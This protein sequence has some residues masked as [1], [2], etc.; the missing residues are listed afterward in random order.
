M[1]EIS[2]KTLRTAHWIMK[3]SSTHHTGGWGENVSKKPLQDQDGK[4]LFCKTKKV[5]I[6]L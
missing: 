3:I 6:K 1:E 4:E 5:F 2:L